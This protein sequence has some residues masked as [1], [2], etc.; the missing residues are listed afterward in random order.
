MHSKSKKKPIIRTVGRGIFYCWV[1]IF[2]FSFGL[3]I[4]LYKSGWVHEQIRHLAED[5]L[6]KQCGRECSFGEVEGSLLSDIT[7]HNLQIAQDK[8]LASGTCLDVEKLVVQYSILD[9]VTGQIRLRSIEVI[10]PQVYLGKDSQ[11]HWALKEVF[12]PT[13]ERKGPSKFKMQIDNIYIRNCYFSMDVGS[14]LSKFSHVDMDV[15]FRVDKGIS[16]INIRRANVFLPQVDTDIDLFEGRVVIGK[17]TVL[18]DDIK[19]ANSTGHLS[20]IGLIQYDPD[21]H[22]TFSTEELQMPAEELCK[23]FLENKNVATGMMDVQGT[24]EG[25]KN[26]VTVN[27]AVSLPQGTLLGY[28]L[29]DLSSPAYYEYRQRKGELTLESFKMILA[30]AEMHGKAQVFHGGGQKSSYLMQGSLSNG[31]F[32]NY[33]KTVGLSSSINGDFTFAGNGWS[34]DQMDADIEL[35]LNQSSLSNVQFDNGECLLELKDRSAIISG[36]FL[37][38]GPYTLAASGRMG[39]DGSLDLDVA[40]DVLRAEYFLSVLGYPQ[41]FGDLAVN[42]HFGGSFKAPQ[43][44]GDLWIT[45]GGFDALRV[46][47]LQFSFDIANL[48]GEPS[49]TSLISAKNV[50]LGNIKIHNLYSELALEPH[51]YHFN[52]I[53]LSLENNIDVIGNFSITQEA[54]Y[55]QL[56]FNNVQVLHP[57]M[58]ML[59]LDQATLTIKPQGFQISPLDMELLGGKLE[60]EGIEIDKENISGDLLLTRLDLENLVKTDLTE[61][62]LAGRINFLNLQFS[63]P[64][65]NP[66]ISL[67]FNMVNGPVASLD[68]SIMLG[69]INYVYPNIEI[70][71]LKYQMGEQKIDVQGDIPFDLA[72]TINTGFAPIPGMNIVVKV[73]N[74]DL[75]LVNLLTNEVFI[76]SGTLD[77]DLTL[78]G[79]L[80]KPEV[81]GKVLAKDT[82]IVIG[83]M[84]SEIRNI[85]GEM[86]FTRNLLSVDPEKPIS[87]DMD[88]GTVLAWGSIYF[89]IPLTMPTFDASIQAN[90]IVLRGIPQVTGIISVNGK[91]TGTPGKDLLAAG[92]VLVQEGLVN[93]EFFASRSGYSSSLNSMD[94]DID[95]L[96][97]NNVWLRNRSADIELYCNMTLRRADGRYE[98]TGELTS[99]RGFFYFLKRDF[100]IDKGSIVFQGTN[101]IN[102]ILDI[103]GSIQIRSNQDNRL[104]PVYI[105]VTGELRKPDIRL[106]SPDYPNLTQQDILTV[107]A[108]NMTWDEYEQMQSSQIAKSQS[109]EYIMR[110]VEDELSRYM[111]SGI[112]LDTVRIHTNLIT[113]EGP[114]SLR[115]TVGKYITRKLYISYTRDIYTAEGQALQAEYYMTDDLSLTGETHEEE[116]KY[117]YSFSVNY[118][119]RY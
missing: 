13:K 62:P 25:G 118:R 32:R 94:L 106:F 98:I 86:Y 53:A 50:E 96:A 115:F 56:S 101:E 4:I 79:N 104:H 31:D 70:N 116:G 44:V 91:L 103:T 65:A 29:Q 77:A 15:T 114:E 102:P 81:S 71:S 73:N 30:G 49:G 108:L 40:S 110:Y 8:T 63:G 38:K 109:A 97:Q 99:L 69:D 82:D 46:A 57:Y 107:L 111:R 35:K 76:S 61:F 58:T 17:G 28:P 83:R 100:V 34:L 93:I 45:D 37:H 21:I 60:S 88:E 112:G 9:F 59:A 52:N 55:K 19:M 119:Y 18:L 95:I 117:I 10:N 113:G 92:D 54:G 68:K 89:P 75:V 16:V 48:F 7:F 74:L 36:L 41:G 66:D 43:A 12:Y 51:S 27:G 2:L 80:L 42:A 78:T 20:T 23:I 5:A 47:N 87:G 67:T 3:G 90:N 84:G 14:P 6:S 24:V 26:W 22:Y 72:G 39:F 105:Y 11:G 33:Q 64:V 85:E 1:V